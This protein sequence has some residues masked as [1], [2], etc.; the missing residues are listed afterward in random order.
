[1]KRSDCSVVRSDD[2]AVPLWTY[3]QINKSTSWQEAQDTAW[4]CGGC[5]PS[6]RCVNSPFKFF[7]LF[8]LV[9][10]IFPPQFTGASWGKWI[11]ALE[12]EKSR[13]LCHSLGTSTEDTHT[14]VSSQNQL[15]M[16]SQGS[17]RRYA[18]LAVCVWSPLLSLGSCLGV[19]DTVADWVY[20]SNRC[21]G[22]TFHFRPVL[23]NNVQ[24]SLGYCQ[25]E[26]VWICSVHIN[27]TSAAAAICHP[28]LKQQRRRV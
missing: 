13:L 3:T 27:I 15:Y 9:R 7:G 20:S 16:N 19:Q 25:W 8:C 12:L 11:L 1:M 17:I 24:C 23:C 10:G 22:L 5:A 21:P 26:E 28:D 6:R 18:G 2:W 14:H 4:M